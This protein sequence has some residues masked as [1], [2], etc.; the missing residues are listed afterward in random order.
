MIYPLGDT[1]LL[2]LL[3]LLL[4]QLLP[5]PPTAIVRRISPV[6]SALTPRIFPPRHCSCW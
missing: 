4:L 6:I 5:F 1:V 2:L 3:L